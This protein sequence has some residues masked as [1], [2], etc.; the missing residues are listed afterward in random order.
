MKKALSILLLTL[1]LVSLLPFPAFAASGQASTYDYDE[2]A[3]ARKGDYVIFG[4]YE[5]DDS[6]KNG[7]EPIEWLVL[8][9]QGKKLLLV[10][11]Y[12]LDCKP[13]YDGY[14]R[15]TW[16][17]STLRTWMNDEFFE[18]AFSEDEQAAISVT[19]VRTKQNPDY[20]SQSGKDCSDKLFVLSQS[21]VN[22]LF[23]NR[24]AKIAE[25]TDYAVAEAVARDTARIGWY[26][27][28]T[29][30]KD[31]FY[32]CGVMAADGGVRGGGFQESQYGYV[33][34]AMWVSVS[35]LEE[36]SP[37]SSAPSGIKGST[38]S[39]SLFCKYCGKSIDGDSLFCKYCGKKQ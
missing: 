7:K 12:C 33:R 21:E 25:P 39:D 26:W 30:G 17:E 37:A 13:F 28:R 1:M 27:L 35:D 23:A 36:S 14:S 10:S 8:D 31:N 22:S 9:Q 6:T 2:M 5:Q 16:Q 20:K 18:E 11:R 24:Q 4:S 19:T 32:F 38:A 15:T 3:S 34:P 29:A